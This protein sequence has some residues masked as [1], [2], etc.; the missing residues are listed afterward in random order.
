[1]LVTPR[2]L[3]CLGQKYGVITMEVLK[4]GPRNGWV[5]LTIFASDT[6]NRR[7]WPYEYNGVPETGL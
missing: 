4:L 2:C 6:E 3:E 7:P 1:M 5:E